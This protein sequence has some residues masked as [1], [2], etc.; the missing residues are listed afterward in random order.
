MLLS[1]PRRRPGGSALAVILV[2]AAIAVAFQA[3]P[4]M[5]QA[6][7]EDKREAGPEAS[8]PNP[9]HDFGLLDYGE[10][11][12]HDFEIRN[13]GTAPLELSDALSSCG[14]TVLDFDPEIAAG[15]RGR[16]RV[17][18]ETEA[19]T[20][21]FAV[22]VSVMTN[23]VDNPSLQMTLKAEL[24]FRVVARPGYA[25]FVTYDG[26]SPPPLSRQVIAA[27]DGGSLDVRSVSSPY[28]WVNVELSEAD[29]RERLAEGGERQ[30]RL[31]VRL[32]PSAPLGPIN[33]SVVVALDHPHQSEIRIPVHGIVQPVLV[34]EPGEIDLGV[35]VPADGV[36]G[37]VRV[38]NTTPDPLELES[39]GTDVP[40]LRA[41]I[42]SAEGGEGRVWY[43]GFELDP[44][45][46]PGPFRGTLQ[47]STTSD[48]LP[49]LEIPFQGVA[50]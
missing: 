49:V 27:L 48:R 35:V 3:G 41:G 19:Q 31:D 6:P 36:R 9:I 34:V 8:V 25:R 38:R 11:V 12:V 33:G 44:T 17:A 14:C 47:V 45:M 40:G 4:L 13:E 5:A 24:A 16:F 43:V 50:R 10:R 18:I 42:S 26:V 28:P 23:D 15:G 1:G 30:W 39:V 32:E 7:S 21:P 22:H 20:G 29:P 37:S 2:V 46:A